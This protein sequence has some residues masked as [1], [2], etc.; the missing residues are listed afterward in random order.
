[1]TEAEITTLITRV[2]RAPGQI[3]RIFAGLTDDQLRAPLAEGEWSPAE[4]LAH[5]R[6]ADDIVAPR[7]YMILARDEPPLPAFDERVWAA[8]AGY[9]TLDPRA[10]LDVYFRRRAELTH[11]LRGTPAEGFDRVGMHET[12]GAITLR[13]VLETLA[14]HEEEHLAQ[15]E[16]G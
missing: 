13:T 11:L 3:A 9:L 1:V 14:S 10:S 8:V 2:L 4:I 15:M 16:A 12:L 7:V 6:A 5:L